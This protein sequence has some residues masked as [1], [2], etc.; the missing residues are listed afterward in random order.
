MFNYMYL[1][2]GWILHIFFLFWGAKRKQIAIVVSLATPVRNW[3]NE[4]ILFTDDYDKPFATSIV[5]QKADST[6]SN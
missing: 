6:L 3:V 1:T 4:G 2:W 5:S